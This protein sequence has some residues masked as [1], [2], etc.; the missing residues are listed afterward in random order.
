MSG[1]A[2]GCRSRRSVGHRADGSGD[3]W[4]CAQ[5]V[6]FDHRNARSRRPRRGSRGALDALG[7]A[8]RALPLRPGAGRHGGVLRGLRVRPGGL[9][10]H[11]RRHRQVRSAALCGVR[12]ARAEPARRQSHGPRPPRHAQGLV[13]AGR[14]RPREITGHGDRRRHRVRAAGRAADLGRRAGDGTGS[15]S[16]SAAG[17]GRGRS[18]RRRRSCVRCPASRSS[19]VSRPSRRRGSRPSPT[20]G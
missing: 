9:G 6:S 18:S 11:D 4:R 2:V 5:P 10:Q 15:G 7:V 20:A 13:R 14:G 1:G 12:R 19:R 16:C 8:V 17:R 3:A